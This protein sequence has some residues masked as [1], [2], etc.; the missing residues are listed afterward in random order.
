MSHILFN[1]PQHSEIS[2][3]QRIEAYAFQVEKLV[4]MANS[5]CVGSVWS[6]Q[7]AQDF[8]VD[9]RQL[10]KKIEQT[11]KD[12][13]E[14]ARR[15]TT[16][17]N[18]TAKIFTERLEE[19][20]SVLTKKVSRWKEAKEK[21]RMLVEEEDLL[22]SEAL[23]LDMA[24]VSTYHAP[25]K[26]IGS[27]NSVSYERTNWKFDLEDLSKVPR[28]FLKVDEEKVKLAI[29]SGT[30]DIAGLKIYS[31]QQTIIKSR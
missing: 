20:I 8:A 14:P 18:N 9:A 24:Q 22:L 6:A 31:E 1:P 5:Y 3:K 30:R 13:T 25:L 12:I 17:V 2:T 7:E 21:E 19:T 15:F 26:N 4:E 28:E 23:N 10:L 29:K 16:K 27:D 11:K